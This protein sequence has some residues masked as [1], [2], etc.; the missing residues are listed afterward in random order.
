MEMM[1]YILG[2]FVAGVTI[3]ALFFRG[4]RSPAIKAATAES[5]NETA[6][7]KDRLERQKKVTEEVI[8]EKIRLTAL[9][10]EL[11]A[12]LRK[13]TAARAAAES[14]SSRIE[15]LNEV[16]RQREDSIA[17][18]RELVST[19]EQEKAT[20]ETTVEKERQAAAEKLVMLEK[21]HDKLSETFKSLSS[22]ALKSNNEQFLEIATTTFEKLHGDSKSELEAREKAV[23]EIVAPVQETLAKVDTKIQ[24]IEDARVS[25]Y[26]TLTEQIK[27]LGSTQ[28]NLRNET[29]KLA[30]ALRTPVTRGSWGEVQL[31][32][33]VE[34]AGMQDHCDFFEQGSVDAGDDSQRADMI[35]RLPG[36]RSVVVDAKTPLGAYMDAIESDDD[37]QTR[38]KLAEHAR[39]VREKITEL[40]KD[41]YLSQFHPEP[42]FVVLFLP[43]EMFFSAALQ[44]DASL[45]EHGASQRVI[46]AAPT[47]LIALL[48]A[49]AYGW[50][51]EHLAENARAISDLGRQL[52]GRISTLAGHWGRVGHNLGAAVDAYNKALTA[53]ESRVLVSARRFKDLDAAPGADDIA[54]FDLLEN[55]PRNLQAPE[56][57]RLTKSGEKL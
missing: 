35:I 32:R 11:T 46:L 21:A 2:A 26:G 28:D 14:T 13:E 42:E 7:V 19:H 39:L 56:L 36:G 43:G 45:I 54:T 38:A 4:Q 24:N 27:S 31:R 17:I 57:V 29:S 41:A 5:R 9:G 55:T 49:V 15:D 3:A 37:E 47:T 44:E 12:D 34:I 8:R 1:L 53:L 18:L 22:E 25:A 48:K 52:Y 40:T 20:L 33:V 10:E 30:N 23:A 6:L 51:E 50:R 16:I